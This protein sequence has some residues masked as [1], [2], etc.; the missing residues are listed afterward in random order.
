[1]NKLIC[2]RAEEL[3]ENL[4]AGSIDL[5]VT[6]PP[7]DNIRH[8]KNG[9]SF[10][11]KAIIDELYRV[12]KDGGVVV[13]VVGDGVIKGSETGNSFRQALYAIDAGFNLHDTMIFEKDGFGFPEHNRYYPSFD[14]MFIWSKGKPITYNPIKDR[15]NKHAGYVK[16]IIS[17]RQVDGSKKR[18]DR[19]IEIGEYGVRFNIWKYG[20]GY[21]K[22]TADKEAYGHPAI[23]PEKLA[24]DHIISWS[25]KGDVV[26]DCFCGSGTTGKMAIKNNRNFIGFDTSQEYLDIAQKR[27]NNYEEQNIDIF[28]ENK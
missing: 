4:D 24:E 6:S 20:V 1:M 8:Y 27:I 23:M 26:L 3:L 25:N 18:T 10:D 22:S 11:Y 2:G 9:Y 17:Q 12:T 13:W 15:K 19:H 16:H 28:A 5:T 7:Y 21:N 14:Y